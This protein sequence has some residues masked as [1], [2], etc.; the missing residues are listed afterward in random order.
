MS[1][2]LT[3]PRY[4]GARWT[5]ARLPA[6]AEPWP[7]RPDAPANP[8]V[9]DDARY[10]IQEEELRRYARD[11]PWK[12]P[13]QTMYFFCDVHADATAFRDSLMASGG[14]ELTGPQRP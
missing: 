5:A 8:F 12:L 6:N 2:S 10:D 3:P 4:L 7:T 14:V 11:K 13:A 9:N 1:A